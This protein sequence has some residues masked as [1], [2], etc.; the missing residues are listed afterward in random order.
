[1]L[2]SLYCVVPRRNV[3]ATHTLYCTAR[4]YHYAIGRGVTKNCA[5]AATS[6]RLAGDIATGYKAEYSRPDLS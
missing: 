5:E 6:F 2:R 3:V 1:M 4:R